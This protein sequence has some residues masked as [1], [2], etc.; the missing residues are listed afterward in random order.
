MVTVHSTGE[1]RWFAVSGV[2]IH[3][4]DGN[5][6]EWIGTFNDI[7]E[8]KNIEKELRIAKDKLTEEKLYLDTTLS[9]VAGSERSLTRSP[10]D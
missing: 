7:T 2:S 4:K 1:Y 10:S 5:V 8:R 6:R 9:I 3:E